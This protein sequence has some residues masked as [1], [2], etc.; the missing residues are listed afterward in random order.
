[1]LFALLFL[2]QFFT[3]KGARKNEK[4]FERINRISDYPLDRK[5]WLLTVI[6]VICVACCY[7]QS[8]VEFDS[9]LNHIGYTEPKVLKGREL[10]EAKNN[11]GLTS[12]Y[13]G[14]VGETLD[15]ALTANRRVTALLDSLRTAGVIEKYSDMTSLLVTQAE[16]DRRTEAWEAYWSPAKVAEVRRLVTAAAKRNGLNPSMFET[17][18]TL[19]ET[20]YEPISLYDA[21][22]L[23]DELLCNYVE[24]TEDGRYI[25]FTSVLMPAENKVRT[26]DVISACPNA[27]AI[28][29]F[30]Y[31][32]DMVRVLND[33]FNLILNISVI[34]VFI[35]LLVSFRSVALAI[36][37]FLPMA[38]SWYTVKG[39][40]GIFGIE[41]NLI[42]I[43]IATFIFGIGVDYSIFMMRGLLAKAGGKNDKL[44]AEH[45]T[46]IFFSAFVLIVVVVA[47]L[48]ATHPAIS[49]IGISTLIGMVSTILITYTIQP[50][51]FRQLMKLKHFRKRFGPKEEAPQNVTPKNDGDDTKNK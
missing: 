40:M 16:R 27:I 32:S 38:L 22:V 6:T 31:T 51:L 2:P 35:V 17:F 25:V 3:E 39:I 30:Y 48:F 11:G 45:K 34:F 47:L 50:F 10:Y 7:T 33:D 20:H 15:D 43:I 18:Y 49:S 1:T 26:E 4:A 24:Q 41:F 44:L 42:N 37:A 19:A 5:P 13:F 8:W 29:P 46:A 28:D 12:Q 9:D 14:A 21:G 36:L 23:P